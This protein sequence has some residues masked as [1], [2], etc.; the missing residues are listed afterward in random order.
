MNS[1]DLLG[2]GE[3]HI[4]TIK[5]TAA[6]CRIKNEPIHAVSYA[7]SKLKSSS[8]EDQFFSHS[9]QYIFNISSDYNLTGD[10][11]L[12]T[13]Y[14]IFSISFSFEKHR[15]SASGRPPEPPAA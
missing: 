12:L 15:F 6:D 5:I 2:Q 11:A 13:L 3:L 1:L 4:V 7:V 14:F 10:E 9:F 8:V